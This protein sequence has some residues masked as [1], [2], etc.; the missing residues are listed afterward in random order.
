[1]QRSFLPR[2]FFIFR[3]LVSTNQCQHRHSRQLYGSK[4]TVQVQHKTSQHLL[5]HGYQW[6]QENNL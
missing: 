3:R 1:M 4:L 5:I 6:K 2:K